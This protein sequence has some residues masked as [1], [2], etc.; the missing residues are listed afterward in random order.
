MIHNI[1]TN[2]VTY[3][4]PLESIHRLELARDCKLAKEGYQLLLSELDRLGIASFYNTIEMS[5]LGHYLPILLSSFPNC[6]NFI[7][8]DFTIIRISM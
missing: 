1:E 3:T 5:V 2:A 8:N 4:C 7:Q 6:V